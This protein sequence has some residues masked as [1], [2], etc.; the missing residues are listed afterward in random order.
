MHSGEV[1]SLRGIGGLE[2]A[3]TFVSVGRELIA[4]A[5][6]PWRASSESRFPI[7]EHANI[8]AIKIMI[9]GYIFL[10]TPPAAVFSS[11]P[12]F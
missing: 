11:T 9:I 2:V 8:A 12:H 4:V 10:T 6:G 1:D 7:K 5:V 3:A